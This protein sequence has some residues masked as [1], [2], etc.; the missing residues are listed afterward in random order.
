[1]VNLSDKSGILPTGYYPIKGTAPA[2]KKPTQK[3][4]Y[5]PFIEDTVKKQD[6][7]KI[8]TVKKTQDHTQE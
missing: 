8:E 3:V 6:P 1:M 4:V 2:F 7:K 5:E